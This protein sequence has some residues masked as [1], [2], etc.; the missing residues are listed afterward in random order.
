MALASNV[1]KSFTNSPP[2]TTNK[3]T[4]TTKMAITAT[5]LATSEVV[6]K[7]EFILPSVAVEDVDVLLAGGDYGNPPG[8]FIDDYARK[9]VG[10]PYFAGRLTTGDDR[11]K[12][13]ERPPIAEQDT[14]LPN[15][16]LYKRFTLRLKYEDR[17]LTNE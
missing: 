15:N 17:V 4:Y 1:F 13:V 3:L 16:P 5:N 6:V 2:F 12:F 11:V 14:M 9:I 10:L 8:A 7:C